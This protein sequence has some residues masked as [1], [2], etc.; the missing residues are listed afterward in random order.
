MLV[1]SFSLFG[2]V[3][4]TVPYYNWSS[5]MAYELSTPPLIQGKGYYS[6]SLSEVY[7]GTTFYEYDNEYIPIET[8]ADY[9][10]WYTNKYYYNWDMPQ[11]Y[12]YYYY[13]E[14][15]YGMA[16]F[17]AQNF[18]GVF[19]PTRIQVSFPGKEIEHNYLADERYIPLDDKDMKKLNRSHTNKPRPTYVDNSSQ[20]SNEVRRNESTSSTQLNEPQITIR[21]NNTNQS[22]NKGTSSESKR[23]L[24]TK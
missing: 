2:Q 22:L 5:P 7:N 20:N 15:D 1:A 14:D 8:W 18:T 11:I 21:Q 24:K 9:Y 23:P 17:I 10:L 16:S 19:Y 13:A 12:Q 3:S 6:D 4:S